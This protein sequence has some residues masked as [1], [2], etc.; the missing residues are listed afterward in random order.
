[1]RKLLAE[2]SLMVEAGMPEAQ[3]LMEQG[4]DWE[5]H[6]VVGM[7]EKIA[8]LETAVADALVVETGNPDFGLG[9]RLADWANP[10]GDQ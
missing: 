1:M 2:L 10:R 9:L 6:K 7:L 8:A 5:W 3:R 4:Q